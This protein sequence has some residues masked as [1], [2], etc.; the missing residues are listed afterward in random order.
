MPVTSKVFS[1]E[2][3]VH[4]YK[5]VVQSWD[6]KI[7]NHVKSGHKAAESIKRKQMQFR[8]IRFIEAKVYFTFFLSSYISHFTA[9]NSINH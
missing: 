8:P 3:T 5:N 1:K 4:I 9:C 7:E 6:L 2:R